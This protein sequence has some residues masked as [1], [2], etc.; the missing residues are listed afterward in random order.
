MMGGKEGKS[1]GVLEERKNGKKQ[2]K[3]QQKATLLN[4]VRLTA[5][6]VAYCEHGAIE[7]LVPLYVASVGGYNGLSPPCCT[8]HLQGRGWV[9]QGEVRVCGRGVGRVEM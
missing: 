7:A 1:K 4:T 2:N 9:G 5:T 6:P 3:T 8:V